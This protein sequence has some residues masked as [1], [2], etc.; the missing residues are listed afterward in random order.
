M[1]ALKS[2]EYRHGGYSVFYVYEPKLRK[3]EKSKYID[4][5]VHRWVVDEFLYEY[6]VRGYIYHSYA[7]IKGKGTHKAVLAVQKA[8]KHCDRI[9]DNWYILKMDIRK[10]F[11]NIDKEV[12]VEILGKKIQDKKLM[13]L[14]VEIVYS[15][16][17]DKGIAIRKFHIADIRQRIFTRM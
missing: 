13:K 3:I 17:G 4:R 11:D 14:I 10:F 12:L 6:F 5:I 15:N 8:M 2:G 1:K 16:G 9:W 7:C